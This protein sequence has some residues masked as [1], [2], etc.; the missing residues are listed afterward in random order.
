M[1]PMGRTLSFCALLAVCAA[2]SRPAP[3]APTSSRVRFWGEVRGDDRFEH[4][5]PG[6]LRFLLRPID[7]SEPSHPEGWSIEILGS[8]S[9][10]NYVGI[11]T[12]PYR[13][14]NPRLIEAWH[15]RN[16]DNSGPNKGQVNAPQRERDF[17]FVVSRSDYVLCGDALDRVLWP[18]AFSDAAVD[19][20]QQVLD[21]VPRG[22]GR[23]TIR[24]MKL[25]GLTKDARP[26]FESMRF[27]VVL[28]LPPK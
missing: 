10:E 26:W 21:H 5:I 13:G 15:F 20:A 7:G 22:E 18:Y 11:A 6:G 27:D 28:Q 8:D 2:L 9:T 4:P 23:L 14:I 19:S 25:G 17:F 12:P 24:A 3:G 1:T 16:A